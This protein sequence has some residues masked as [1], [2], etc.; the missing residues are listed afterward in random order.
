MDE[1]E[2]ARRSIM[3]HEGLRLYVYDDETGLA[4]RPGT[5]VRG[6]PTI[7]WGRNLVDP[8]ITRDEADAMLDADLGRAWAIA[9]RFAGEA[10]SALSSV[11]RAVLIDMAFNLGHRLDRFVRMRDALRDGDFEAAAR[12]MLDSRW[13]RQVNRRAERLAEAMRTGIA[14]ES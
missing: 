4:V 6:N 8:G 2:L 9:R 1:M 12:E 3:R 5:V 14:T 13:A 11:R 10:W 7:G